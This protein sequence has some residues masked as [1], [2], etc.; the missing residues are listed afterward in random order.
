MYLLCIQA[1]QHNSLPDDATHWFVPKA[2]AT[3]DPMLESE[4]HRVAAGYQPQQRRIVCESGEAKAAPRGV[5]RNV[6]RP[7]ATC[8]S[9]CCICAAPVLLQEP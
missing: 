8:Q 3:R 5:T 9:L 1:T 6:W 2:V 7:R 4:L